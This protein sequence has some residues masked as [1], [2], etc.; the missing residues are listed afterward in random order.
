[1][2]APAATPTVQ[3]TSGSISGL[4]TDPRDGRL[5]QPVLAFKGVPYAAAPTGSDRF[6]P[7]LAPAPW[8][9]VREAHHHAPV[10]PQRPSP[11]EAVLGGRD[12]TM[13][14]AE[15]LALS[16]WTPGLDGAKR[17]VLFWV[18]GGAFVTGSG[19]VPWYDGT[20]FAGN[21]DVVLVTINYRLGALGFTH[22]GPGYTNAGIRDQM[23]A[24]R[25]VHEHI[26]TF[27]GDPGNVT[28]F[29]ESAGAMS[30]GTLLAVPSATGLFRRAILQSGAASNALSA[31]NAARLA[32]QLR[33]Q[34]GSIDAR[35]ATVDQLLDA[36]VAVSASRGIGALPFAPAVD[37]E[38]LT[39]HPLDAISE[40]AAAGIDVMIGTNAEEMRLFT[41]MDPSAGNLDREKLIKRTAA[42]VSPERAATIVDAYCAA[43]PGQNP[44][45]TWVAIASDHVFVAPARRLLGAHH[46]HGNIYNYLFQWQTPAFGGR[47]GS[48]HALEIP[49]VFDNLHQPGIEQFTGSGTERQQ[50][51]VAMNAAWAAFARTGS[52]APAG[53]WP[54]WRPDQPATRVFDAETGVINGWRSEEVSL[55]LA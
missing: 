52:P 8:S 4:R 40:G 23:A 20:S 33:V 12:L 38:I 54:A 29:G 55:W 10:S 26:A 5:R 21:H 22:H 43:R 11:L 15:C 42:F 32:E 46:G 19:G 7:P 24:L 47:L 35:S 50:I 13:S 49:F 25:W 14:E 6:G 51:A 28:I 31:D 36:Q 48:C 17:P 37:G 2:N 3:V 41:V 45:D 16:V 30:V 18:H 27:G 44:A 34:L 9:G 39:H 53:E 1:M